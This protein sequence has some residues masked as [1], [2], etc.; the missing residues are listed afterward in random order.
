[1]GIGG[2]QYK[3][4][5][6]AAAAAAI[7]ECR[8]AL[9][10]C[11]SSIVREAAGGADMADWRHYPVG[12]VYDA[13]THAQYFY[14][15]H[16]AENRTA[17]EHGHFHLFLRAEGIPP[18]VAPLLLPEHAVANFAIPPQAA[19]LKRGG[20]DEVCHLAAIAI[21]ARGEPIRLFT[22]NRWVTGETWY[23]AEDVIGLLDRFQLGA[24]EASP[25][26]NRWLVAVVQLFRAEIAQLLRDRDAAV[27]ARRRQRR[28]P[29]FEDPRFEIPSSIDIELDARLAA[30][31]RSA[32]EPPEGANRRRAPRLPRMADG[33]IE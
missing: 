30:V 12:E 6:Q 32:A 22:T 11:G 10:A 1:V 20:R 2:L 24:A 9:A 28:V 23:R 15:R 16:P 18:G 7:R 27:M 25:L 17:G 26:L 31:E 8:A 21:D 19:P 14:H 29:V 5:P 4:H 13:E 3:A 33:W